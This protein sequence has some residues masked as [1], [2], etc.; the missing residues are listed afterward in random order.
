MNEASRIEALCDTTGRNLLL[1]DSFAQRC[2]AE[3]IDLGPYPLR[4]VAAPQ[5]L[6]SVAEG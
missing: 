4:G 6:W 5:K 3:L 2:A 1:S